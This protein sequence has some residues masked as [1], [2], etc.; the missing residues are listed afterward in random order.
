[1]ET[2]EEFC[3]VSRQK[4]NYVKSKVFAFPNLHR[5]ETV[6]MSHFLGTSL[7]NDLGTYLGTNIINGETNLIL[8][9]SLV[10]SKKYWRG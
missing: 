4:V 10:K 2:L 1:M 3:H 9:I 5:R 6:E 7:T 8:K